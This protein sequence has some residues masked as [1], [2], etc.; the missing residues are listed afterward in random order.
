M[1]IKWTNRYS[2]ESGYVATVDDAG[3]HFINAADVKD[4]CNYRMT[5]TAEKVIDKLYEYGEGDNNDFEIVK[6]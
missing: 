1:K 5:K 3:R 2:G 6:G 4:A